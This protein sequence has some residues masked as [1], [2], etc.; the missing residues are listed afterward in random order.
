[1][2][3]VQWSGGK[4]HGA[5]EAKASIMHDDRESRL[6]HTH[7]N[8]DIDI[9]KTPE[10]WS[11]RNL[12]FLEKC[13]KYDRLMETVKIKRK[14]TGKNQTVTLQKLVI[15]IPSAMQN[16]PN[17]DRDKSIAWATEVCKILETRYGTLFID[18][19][20]HFDEVHVYLDPKKDPSDPDR[21]VWSRPHLHAAIVPAIE[22]EVDGEKQLVLNAKKF[23]GRSKI[24]S[25]N[26]QIQEMT[27]QKFG[28]DFMTGMGRGKKHNTVE[29]LKSLTVEEMRKEGLRLAEERREAEAAKAEAEQAR[30]EAEKAQ[31]EIAAR[32]AEA[33]RLDE[34]IAAKKKKADY[35]DNEISKKMDK[36]KKE[37]FKYVVDV[38]TAAGY[39]F[40]KNTYKIDEIL[41][42]F[43]THFQG[44]SADLDKKTK[45]AAETEARVA[46]E[47]SHAEEILAEAEKKE[48]AL[49]AEYDMKTQELR[50]KEE[51]LKA[52][53]E[54][55]MKRVRYARHLL[56]ASND[57]HNRVQKATGNAFVVRLDG[58]NFQK[59]YDGKLRI[60]SINNAVDEINRE[61]AEL[62]KTKRELIRKWGVLQNDNEHKR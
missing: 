47:K 12:C 21:Y 15:T 29:D 58:N 28:M 34:E 51:A 4:M 35:L 60:I 39:I 31:E 14:S 19:D 25:L 22:E 40:E 5:S 48:S 53:R 36:A 30:A 59:N 41:Q 7:S 32:V 38:L 42:I 10:N 44:L 46:E 50:E 23:C 3:A 52:D 8:E 11:Y 56:D 61:H 13:K 16:G 17:Y 57:F 20:L 49:A 62:E 18:A 33:E 9:T 2:A 1:M 6:I 26:N 24:T 43:R 55:Y 45:C 37:T 54:E 27:Q